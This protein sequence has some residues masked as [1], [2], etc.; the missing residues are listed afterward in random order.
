MAKAKKSVHH[1]VKRYELNHTERV[2]LAI[3]GVFGF[4]LFWRGLSSIMDSVP[5]LNNEM[6]LVLLGLVLMYTSGLL[7]KFRK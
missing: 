4:I 3:I 6:F 1:R 5:L 7:I 2:L